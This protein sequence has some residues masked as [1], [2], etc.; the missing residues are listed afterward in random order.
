[1]QRLGVHALV[2]T[3]HAPGGVDPQVVG[4]I[5]ALDIERERSHRP[6]PPRS[7]DPPRPVRVDQ[8]MT[9]WDDLSLVHYES[10]LTL[11]AKEIYEMFQGT[12]LTHLLVIETQADESAVAC[13]ILSRAALA[14]RLGRRLHRE[15]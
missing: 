6:T 9:S 10:L 2:V 14:E 4:L 3:N 7:S 11:T 13:G 12:G 8:V 1:M 5:T 15:S